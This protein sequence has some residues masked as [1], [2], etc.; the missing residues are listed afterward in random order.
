MNSVTGSTDCGIVRT[1]PV[2]EPLSAAV[3]A[4]DTAPVSPDRP[5]PVG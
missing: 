4:A 2:S 1:G 3:T 5:G